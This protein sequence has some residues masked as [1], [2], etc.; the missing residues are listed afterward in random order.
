MSDKYLLDD[1]EVARFLVTGYHLIE[2][3]LPAGLN[4]NVAAQLDAL[5]QNPGDGITEAVPES[6]P[7]DL[8]SPE[9]FGGR[10]WERF[11]EGFR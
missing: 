3:E 2:P 10:V 6:Y 7:N 4:E 1:V 9:R 8:H 11:G 5:E